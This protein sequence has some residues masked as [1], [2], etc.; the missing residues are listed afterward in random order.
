MDEEK[1]RRNGV[2]LAIRASPL[3]RAGALQIS[4][5]INQGTISSILTSCSTGAL[6]LRRSKVT[7]CQASWRSIFFFFW[8]GKRTF[9][10]SNKK[11]KIWSVYLFLR[12][13]NIANFNYS[14]EIIGER[15]SIVGKFN[16]EGVERPSIQSNW[17]R[18]EGGRLETPGCWWIDA[19][20]SDVHV[21]RIIDCECEGIIL[22]CW[23]QE[24][25]LKSS[26]DIPIVWSVNF[27][28][29]FLK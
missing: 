1:R 27:N 10:L 15:S 19:H 3:F 6:G 23:N 14:H 8:E 28:S 17:G 24:V 20:S 18:I 12:W 4:S 11:K 29:S 5:T 21:H 25:G 9:C 26:I 13:M 22:G 2:T 16:S 7:E